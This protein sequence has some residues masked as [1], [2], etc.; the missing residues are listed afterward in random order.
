MKHHAS[1]TRSERGSTLLGL[2]VVLGVLLAV[3][4][5]GG[6]Y[7]LTKT[8][9]LERELEQAKQERIGADIAQLNAES[10][11]R[12]NTGLIQ[13]EQARTELRAVEQRLVA[14][15][16]ALTGIQRDASE[17][18]QGE[19]GRKLALKPELLRQAD[20]FFD[21]TL[22]ELPR[23]DALT[24]RIEAG[25]RLALQVS[26]TA[27]NV[28]IDAALRAQIAELSAFAKTTEDALANANAKLGALKNEA[29]ILFVPE[30]RTLP[31][32]LDQA[33]R[34][35]REAEAARLTRENAPLVETARAD[36]E[37]LR[38]QGEAN[39][40]ATDAKIAEAKRQ[41]AIDARTQS[42]E[43]AIATLKTEA[44]VQG[45]AEEDKRKAMEAAAEHKRRL[46]EAQKP[47]VAAK[48]Q[49]FLAAGNWQ[50]GDTAQSAIKKGPV[51]LSKLVAKG[52]LNPTNAGLRA[53]AVIATDRRND[54]PHWEDRFKRTDAVTKPEPRAELL[55]RQKLLIDYGEALVELG[56]LAK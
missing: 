3:C 53:L 4:I 5:V 29:Q 52:A 41:A 17:L 56:L 11:T 32:S 27:E 54:R 47:E 55:A 30:G 43:Q 44:Q 34:R 51:S 38:A 14:S 19:V 35:A 33:L 36:A 1:P 20:Y 48:L 6:W 18:A 21:F 25:R 12:K 50:P 40:I 15:T 49:P 28:Q 37:K 8:N 2:A 31:E 45:M 10:V 13:Q 39:Q 7:L 16:A 26:Q 24:S 42:T 22:K 23:A 46:V 9:R